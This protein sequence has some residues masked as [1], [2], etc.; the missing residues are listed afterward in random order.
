MLWLVMSSPEQRRT[1]AQD[2][3]QGL[4]FKEGD[5][6][7]GVYRVVKRTS[8]HVELE[9]QMPTSNSPISGLIT[10]SLRPRNDGAALVSETIQWTKKDS[11]AILPVERWVGGFLHSMA[12][13][14]LVVTG[15][16]YLQSLSK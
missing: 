14:W 6:V 11:G 2:Y 16:V 12:S 10:I 13:R 9:L 5:V 4:D 3:I 15:A 7:C 1:F 8:L